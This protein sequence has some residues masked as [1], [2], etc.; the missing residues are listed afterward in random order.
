MVSSA[1]LIRPTPKPIT[2]I[3][4]IPPISISNVVSAKT[5][6]IP[7]SLSAISA[8]KI[9]VTILIRTL[10]DLNFFVSVTLSA[11]KSAKIKPAIIII[12]PAIRCGAHKK[13]LVNMEANCSN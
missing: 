1:G 6:F 7:I 9:I 11:R 12:I 3:R 5:R 4:I 10:I 2:K 8:K 13:I